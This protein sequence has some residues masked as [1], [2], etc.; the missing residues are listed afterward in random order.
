[1]RGLRILTKEEKQKPEKQC[2]WF[3][4]AVDDGEDEEP[5]TE[6]KA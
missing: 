2:Q 6:A 5:E 3:D 1:M 4:I